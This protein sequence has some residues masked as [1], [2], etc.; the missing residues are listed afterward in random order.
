MQLGRRWFVGLF[1]IAACSKPAT[2]TLGTSKLLVANTAYTV[3][4]TD[5]VVTNRGASM[6]SVLVG[7]DPNKEDHVF[8]I[9][10]DVAA[11][12]ETKSIELVGNDAQV[13]CGYR[14]T[15]D[16]QGFVFGREDGAIVVERAP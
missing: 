14:F 5:V 16:P 1:V 12:G 7:N 9:R 15:G 2:I 11:K 13:V 6:R 10:L 3:A 4:G 8:A